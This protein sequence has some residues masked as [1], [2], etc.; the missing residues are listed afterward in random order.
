MYTLSAVSPLPWTLANVIQV[1]VPACVAL[2]STWAVSPAFLPPIQ[3][4]LSRPVSFRMRVEQQAFLKGCDEICQQQTLIAPA[5][6]RVALAGHIAEFNHLCESR[7]GD[8]RV[9]TRQEV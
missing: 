5:H 9:C 8:P 4:L 2:P 7:H 3:N 1:H 6:A